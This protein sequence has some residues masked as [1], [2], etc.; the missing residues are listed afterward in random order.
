MGKTTTW[1]VNMKKLGGLMVR[2]MMALQDFA[3]ANHA[4]QVLEDRAKSQAEEPKVRGC[5]VFP[6]HAD[7]AYFRSIRDRP[8]RDRDFKKGVRGQVPQ[9]SEGEARLR[10]AFHQR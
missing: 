10:F 4:M 6:A 7:I 2:L 3:L 5:K 8:K 1:M 9:W